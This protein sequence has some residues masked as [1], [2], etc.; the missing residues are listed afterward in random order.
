MIPQMT[1]L[2]PGRNIDAAVDV[3]AHDGRGRLVLRNAAHGLA[4]LRELQEHLKRDDQKDGHNDDISI[5]LGKDE[6]ADFDYAGQE[7][8]NREGVG[9]VDQTQ[10]LGND[11][12]KNLGAHNGIH[13]Q[14]HI[15]QGVEDGGGDQTAEHEHHDERAE[16]AQPDGPAEADNEGSAE[17]EGGSGDQHIMCNVQQAGGL[18]DQR[19]FHA[20][21]SVHEAEGNTCD[22]QLQDSFKHCFPP[23]LANVKAVQPAYPVGRPCQRLQIYFVSI[24][25]RKP[26]CTSQGHCP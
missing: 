20:D 15:A 22:Q 2:R 26:W 7:A 1:Q 16:D 6:I 19:I 21:Q 11:L 8:G 5:R 14:R 10:G 13:G 9:T 25:P 24:T 23:F 17:D 3:D 12:G 4:G 18:P